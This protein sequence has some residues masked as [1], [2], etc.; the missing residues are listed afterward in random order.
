[1]LL[2]TAINAK[3]IHSNPAIY[4][5]KAY[6]SDFSDKV[7]L[8][9]Y[10][11][12]QNPDEV[13][14]DIYARNPDITAFSCY[15]W[16]I[17]YIIKLASDLKQV[18]PKSL[19][20]LGGPE[21]SHDS[22]RILDNHSYI[23]YIIKG[24][25]E[26]ALHSFAKWY[27]DKEGSLSDIKGLVFRDGKISNN[28]IPEPLSMDDCIFPYTDL[29]EFSN[30]ILYYESSRGCP[31]SCSYCL[32]SIEKKVRFRNLEKVKNEISFF[33]EKEA[34]QVKF[35][36]RTFNCHS[37]RAYEIWK[38]IGEHD[39]GKTNFHFEIAGDLLR[40]EDVLLFKDFRPGLI[41]MEIGIQSTNP[42]TLK[43]VNR[44]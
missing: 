27:F 4:Q 24:E 26:K 12:N 3:Y 17:E 44:T 42:Y 39:N 36:D 16:N 14:R 30:R 41:Q 31:F 29:S 18:L 7:Q 21:V 8:A 20:L 33:L 13:F 34:A 6:L 35:I 37:E 1:M 23:D 28:N 10:T 9:E 19:I 40:E 25:G 5:L 2:L 15:I 11:I 32:S 38:Y 43:A 22:E